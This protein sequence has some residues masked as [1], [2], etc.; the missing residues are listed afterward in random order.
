VPGW[1]ARGHPGY[2]GYAWYRLHI[3]VSG[4]DTLALSGPTAV[5]DGYTVFLNGVRLGQE[6]APYSIRPH[7]FVLPRLQSATIAI[8]VWVASRTVR[9][10]P[11]DAGGIHIAPA[12]GSV[13]AIH[14]HYVAQWSQTLWGY[15]VDLIEPVAFVVLA[16]VALALRQRWMAFALVLTAIFRVNQVTFFWGH[17]ETTHFYLAVRTILGP[18]SIVAWLVAWVAWFRVRRRSGQWLAVM[19]AILISIGLFARQL[20]ALH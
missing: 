13:G 18:L 20:S 11:E 3:A 4:D 5:D 16:V 1:T 7:Y 17:F 19:A 6:G 12:L 9:A 14:E 8:R 15:V 2:S 10:S